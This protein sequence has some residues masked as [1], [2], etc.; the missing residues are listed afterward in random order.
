MDSDSVKIL[1]DLFEAFVGAVFYD[2]QFD[3]ELTKAC[4]MPLIEN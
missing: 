3:I 1:G 4:I 2:T